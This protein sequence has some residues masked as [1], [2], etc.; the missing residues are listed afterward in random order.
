MRELLKNTLSTDAVGICPL[1]DNLCLPIGYYGTSGHYR[2]G[3]GICAIFSLGCSVRNEA[4]LGA[5]LPQ[6][7]SMRMLDLTRS[8][9][10]SVRSPSCG[11]AD[12]KLCHLA[13][14]STSIEPHL[15]RKLSAVKALEQKRILETHLRA[16]NKYSRAKLH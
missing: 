5:M 10:W 9:L 6:D 2:I 8:G 11:V 1:S 7:I 15:D 16:T 14:G 4:A 3:E 12:G 13:S